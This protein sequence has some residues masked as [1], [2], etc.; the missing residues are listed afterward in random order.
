MVSSLGATVEPGAHMQPSGVDSN[1]LDDE[2]SELDS[3]DCQ[4]GQSN[5]E[6]RTKSV[7]HAFW[8][9]SPGCQI[10]ALKPSSDFYVVDLSLRVDPKWVLGLSVSIMDR[11]LLSIQMVL[12]NQRPIL[13]S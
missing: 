4:A 12:R 9:N 5:Q 1:S 6:S 11:S 10:P 8:D 13:T 3:K 7:A 2:D